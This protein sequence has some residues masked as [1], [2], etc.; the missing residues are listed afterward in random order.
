LTA[1]PTIEEAIASLKIA[2]R[3][4]KGWTMDY[5]DAIIR[6]AIDRV[7]APCVP[8]FGARDTRCSL[9]TAGCVVV[10]EGEKS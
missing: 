3:D 5:A 8:K 10:H 1:A 4:S 7:P 2:L 6:D 9:G